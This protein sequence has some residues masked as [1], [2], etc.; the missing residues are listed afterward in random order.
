M[1]D[2]LYDT[3]ILAWSQTQADLLSRIARGQR[4]NGVDWENVVEEI[5]D[6]GLSQLSSVRGLLRQAM[7]HLLKLHLWP[8]DTAGRHWR[9]GID[10]F[11]DDA[12]E[13][14]APSMRQRLDLEKIWRQSRTSMARA[15]GIDPAVSSL[16]TACP[17]TLDDL[18]AGD[19]N[20]LLAALTA[21][22]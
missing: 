17:W 19:Q 6:V 13:R 3:D 2:G 7:M 21:T 14:Y 15:S 11:L 5:A 9:T 8:D 4:V 10:V 18:L 20:A 1:A 12:A 16:P 22:S